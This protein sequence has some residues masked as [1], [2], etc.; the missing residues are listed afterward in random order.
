MSR[1]RLGLA[2]VSAL[3]ATAAQ[4]TYGAGLTNR[5]CG[6]APIGGR[7]P[8]GM[9]KRYVGVRVGSRQAQEVSHGIH[10]EYTAILTL[11]YRIQVPFDRIGQDLMDVA[12]GGFDDFAETV[13]NVIHGDVINNRVIGAAN[14][15]LTSAQGKFTTALQFESDDD[16]YPVRGD[17]FC[18]ESDKEVGIVQNIRFGK[19]LFTKVYTDALAAPI[20]SFP[21][22]DP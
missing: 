8:A 9:G 12:S 19:C 17:W 15:S 21:P 7:P 20:A 14:A 10:I 5:E 22:L 11:T 1:K 3:K 16:P 18:A 2:I 4:P 13:M 6:L